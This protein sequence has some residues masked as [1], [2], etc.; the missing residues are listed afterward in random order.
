LCEHH[1]RERNALSQFPKTILADGK[2]IG[3]ALSAVK[4]RYDLLGRRGK[5]RDREQ[6]GDV[7]AAGRMVA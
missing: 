6:T 2:T 7:V 5:S 1:F 4:G 3:Q